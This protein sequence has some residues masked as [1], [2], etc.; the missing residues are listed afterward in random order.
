MT[1]SETCA[2]FLALPAYALI[3]QIPYPRRSGRPGR[4]RPDDLVS[5]SGT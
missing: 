2:E 1:L 3:N 5:W 4:L